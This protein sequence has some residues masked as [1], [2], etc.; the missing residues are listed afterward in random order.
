VVL[1]VIVVGWPSACCG[2]CRSSA[3]S[4]PPSGSGPRSRG[5]R[6]ARRAI[7]SSGG[8]E[9]GLALARRVSARG[10]ISLA[11]LIVVSIGAS[12]LWRRA[13]PRHG[14]GRGG[15]G[16]GLTAME[17]RHRHPGAHPPPLHLLSSPARG[18]VLP[19]RHRA[20]TSGRHL[21]NGVI[22]PQRRPRLGAQ[23]CITLKLWWANGP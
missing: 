9:P 15:H 19:G 10:D 11:N 17:H 14:R 3:T 5:V 22:P 20:A 16:G 21:T 1:G 23:S 6:T 18:L 2:G 13:V 4:C 7:L 12:A 8:V